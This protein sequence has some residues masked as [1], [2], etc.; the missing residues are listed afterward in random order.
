MGKK[1]FFLIMRKFLKIV[2][3]SS[4]FFLYKYVFELFSM[5]IFLYVKEVFFE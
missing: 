2:V 5:Y 3:L 1:L 4:D